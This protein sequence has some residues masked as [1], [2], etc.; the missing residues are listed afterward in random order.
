MRKLVAEPEAARRAV[1]LVTA[2]P[3]QLEYHELYSLCDMLDPIL[4]S[5]ERHDLLRRDGDSW[6]LAR[7]RVYIDQNIPSWPMRLII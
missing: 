7:R 4:F 2:S 5:S 1:L 3:M 6:K